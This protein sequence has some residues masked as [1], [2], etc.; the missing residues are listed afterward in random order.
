LPRLTPHSPVA[1]PIPK[2]RGTAAEGYPFTWSVYT[3]LRGE[4]TTKHVVTDL[5]QLAIDLARFLSAL[6]RLDSAAGP[7]TGAHNFF[8]GVPLKARDQMT[9]T[10]IASLGERIDVKAV[11]AAWEAAPK[12]TDAC[13]LKVD[14][15]FDTAGG[16]RLGYGGEQ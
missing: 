16:L 11:T 2:V 8:R 15:E 12:S 6:Q 10:A 9:R 13:C 3:W 14:S 5:N 4:N 7:S 1:I